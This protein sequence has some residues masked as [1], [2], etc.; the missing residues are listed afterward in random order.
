MILCYVNEY[1]V[2]NEISYLFEVAMCY[3]RRHTLR[4]QLTWSK[5]D[6]EV[7]DFLSFLS[8]S[9]WTSHNAW[10]SFHSYKSRL[11]F[12][13]F[14]SSWSTLSRRPFAPSVSSWTR[15]SLWSFI[16]NLSLST[17]PS[18]GSLRPGNAWHSRHTIGSWDAWETHY[19]SLK[20]KMIC[21]L[22]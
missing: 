16:T 8:F 20:V 12:Y 15:H 7:V 19:R 17:V 6:L 21:C 2:G 11:T 3:L 18:L 5:E 14:D 22:M 4:R 1:Y 9:S 10:L 13:P